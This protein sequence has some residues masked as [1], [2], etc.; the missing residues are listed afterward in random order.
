MWHISVAVVMQTLRAVFKHFSVEGYSPE[1]TADR[2]DSVTHTLTHTHTAVWLYSNKWGMLAALLSWHV[3]CIHNHINCSYSTT[4]DCIA[5]V[6]CRFSLVIIIYTQ[7]ICD[8]FS[9]CLL[10]FFISHNHDWH[11]RGSFCVK[12][13]AATTC[14]QWLNY[15]KVGGGTLHFLSSFPSTPFPFPPLSSLPLEVGPLNSARGSGGAL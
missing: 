3:L 8:A 6:C 5:A 12:R 1:P 2:I 11:V 10:S 15:S 9:H 4:L 14:R 13:H 7:V